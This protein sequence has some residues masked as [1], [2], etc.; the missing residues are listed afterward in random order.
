M[1]KAGQAAY[2]IGVVSER[3]TGKKTALQSDVIPKLNSVL[4]LW[5]V[6]FST[7][8]IASFVWRA[9]GLDSS[10]LPFSTSCHL[11][12][13]TVRARSGR[14]HATCQNLMREL[15]ILLTRIR[16]S[17]EQGVRAV[18]ILGP[19]CDLSPLFV[20]PPAP[21]CYDLLLTVTDA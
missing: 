11:L 16:E 17:H 4:V 6:S 21:N 8:K 7:N 18:P 1:R 20:P 19:G 9:K 2:S 12:E 3:G 15:E 10:F 5:H 14:T 13:V